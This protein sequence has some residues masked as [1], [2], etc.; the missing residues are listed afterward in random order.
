MRLLVAARRQRAAMGQVCENRRLKSEIPC[1]NLLITKENP[2]VD[3][4]YPCFFVLS[5]VLKEKLFLLL[6]EL[7][8]ERTAFIRMSMC[9]YI[10]RRQRAA[11]G[12]DCEGSRAGEAQL[13][14]DLHL[15]LR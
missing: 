15:G 14:G 4:S 3:T 7:H 13:P 11:V 8:T 10:A 12:Q 9:A 6:F 1:S 5:K 2:W